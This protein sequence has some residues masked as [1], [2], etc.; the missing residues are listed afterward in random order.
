MRKQIFSEYGMQ[1][2]GNIHGYGSLT[3]CT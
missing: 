1:F 3:F 2:I